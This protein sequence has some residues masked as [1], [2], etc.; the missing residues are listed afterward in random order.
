MKKPVVAIV[1]ESNMT[2]IRWTKSALREKAEEYKLRAGEEVAFINKEEILTRIVHRRTEN[3]GSVECLEGPDVKSGPDK[4]KSFIEGMDYLSPRCRYK[5]DQELAD[6][7]YNFGID[8]RDALELRMARAE[9]A[10][11]KVAKK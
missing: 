4:V 5:K 3:L 2:K 10:A 7:L 8:R 6:T 9:A 11:K 1:L